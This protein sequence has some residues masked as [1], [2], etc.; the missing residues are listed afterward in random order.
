MYLVIDVKVKMDCNFVSVRDSKLAQHVRVLRHDT[1]RE[2]GRRLLTASVLLYS[3]NNPI[4]CYLW[5][6]K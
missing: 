6:S 5:W 1:A 3:S 4:M 2:V